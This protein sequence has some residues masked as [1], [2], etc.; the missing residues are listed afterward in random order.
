MAATTDATFEL[1]IGGRE[2]PSSSGQREPLT[3]PATGEAVATVAVGTPDDA[4]AAMEV[5]ERA[6]RDSNWS[7]DDGAR[8]ARALRRLADLLEA[9]S[10]AFARLETRNEGKPLRESR[11]DIGYVVRT[12]EYC[13]GLADKIEGETIPVPGARFDYT[14]REP[15]GVTVHIAPWNYP[16]L[17]SVRSVA[18]ALAAGNAVVLKPASLTPLSAIAFARLAHE[19]GIPDGILNVVIGRGREVGEA[20]VGDPRCG[21]VTFT[22]SGE[23]GRRIAE[24]AA[25]RMVP[26]TLELGGKGPAIVLADA[27]VERAAR[28]IGYGIF[29]N[30]GQMCWAASR[31]IVHES[32]RAPLVERV[33]AIAEGLR[34]GPGLEDGVEMGPLVSREQA[35][36]VLGYVDD[37]RSSGGTVVT[38]GTRASDGAL[39]AGHFVRPTVL[40]DVP[41]DARAVREEIFGP[42]LTVSSFTDPDE[43]VREA[44][45]T[46]Y[47][48]LAT[49]W[50][51]ELGLAHSLARRIEAGMVVV[52]EAPVTFP[53]APFGGFKGSGLGF[54]QGTRS[55]EA[56][57]RRKNVL[58]NLGAPKTRPKA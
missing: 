27:D 18:P 34:L 58:V 12:L 15:L 51:R 44:N 54:E 4:R 35:D 50:T 9:Q 45:R 8:R 1:F 11:V 26:A 57:S 36:R 52:N 31:L 56:Y 7:T 14:V 20:L 17:L 41:P 39:A 5:A 42:V 6:F 2:V 37:A 19:A 22:G 30:A 23:V 16:L 29:G 40:A 3:D 13:A 48:L 24:L 43:A 46:P 49:L 47:G 38:G 55:L 32:L 25:Q 21:S 53:Q 28:A 33:R 10:E